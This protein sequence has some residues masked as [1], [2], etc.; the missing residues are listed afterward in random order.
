M[1]YVTHNFDVSVFRDIVY[2]GALAARK[3]AVRQDFG[4]KSKRKESLKEN[5]Y[6]KVKASNILYLLIQDMS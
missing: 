5:F 2:L 4:E 3:C 6:R 1:T